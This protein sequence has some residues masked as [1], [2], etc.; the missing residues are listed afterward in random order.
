MEIDGRAIPSTSPTPGDKWSLTLTSALVLRGPN[1]DFLTD[2][3]IANLCAETGIEPQA[4]WKSRGF[5]ETAP[6][7]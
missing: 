4:D 7:G 6:A 5:A 2:L 3:D 1:L